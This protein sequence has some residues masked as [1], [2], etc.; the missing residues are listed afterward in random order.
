MA[1]IVAGAALG[2]LI[3]WT[4]LSAS[5]YAIMF[6]GFYRPHS[7]V[8]ARQ[9][10]RAHRESQRGEL[11]NDQALMVIAA[12]SGSMTGMWWPLGEPDGV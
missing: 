4:I 11:T 1:E 6:R 9:L 10:I 12:A 2:L 3:S 7:K 5:W 8:I